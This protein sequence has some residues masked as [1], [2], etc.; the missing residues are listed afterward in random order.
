MHTYGAAL[1]ARLAGPST[2]GP[3]TP[4]RP[5]PGGD[6]GPELTTLSPVKWGYNARRAG[7]RAELLA[8]SICR[9]HTPGP[10]SLAFARVRSPSSV[11]C[12]TSTHCQSWTCHQHFLLSPHPLVPDFSLLRSCQASP[13]LPSKLRSH[14]SPVSTPGPHPGAASH[15]L[16]DNSEGWQQL[17]VCQGRAS[18]TTCG[19]AM[20]GGTNV[21]EQE[22]RGSL[23][24]L[25]A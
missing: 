10:T 16:L 24:A 1:K 14:P 5:V 13:V 18:L 7:L 11:Y 2:Y 6:A 8:V 21:E 3:S 22:R 9:E 25:P 17:T 15:E 20:H 12:S 23:W 19:T 4:R